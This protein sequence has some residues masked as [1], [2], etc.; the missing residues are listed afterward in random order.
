MKTIV[1]ILFFGALTVL[2]SMAAMANEP[3]KKLEPAGSRNRNLIIYKAAKK[4][5]GGRV[6]IRQA[7]GSLVSEQVLQKRKLLIDFENM[8]MGSYTIRISK[9]DT[10]KEFI[11]E[12]K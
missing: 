9:G 12:K 2:L 11:F 1:K 10:V 6:E 8:M 3:A 4:M 5:I 7:N